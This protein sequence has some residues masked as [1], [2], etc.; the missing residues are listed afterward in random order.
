MRPVFNAHTIQNSDLAFSTKM[1][2]Q[3]INRKFEDLKVFSTLFLDY[4]N[5]DPKLASFVS[6][7]PNMESIKNQIELKKNSFGL[8]QRQI[9]V[10]RLS[11]Q[12]GKIGLSP[13]QSENLELLKKENTF[14]VSCGHQLNIAGGPVY[15]AY[16]I[17]S[18]IKLAE[19]LSKKFTDYQF[20]PIHWM[21]TEDHDLEEIS[22]FSFFSNKIEVSIPQQGAVGKMQTEGISDQLKKIKDFPEWMEA[23]YTKGENLTEATRL[24]IQSVF[25]SMGLLTIDGDDMELKGSLSDSQLEELLNP[26]VETKVAEN[27]DSLLKLGYKPQINPRKINLFYLEKDRRIRLEESDGKIQTIDEQFVWEKS[28]AIKFFKESPEKLSPNVALRPLYSQVLLPDVAFVGGPAEISY[29]LQLKKVFEYKNVPFPILFPRYSGLYIPLAQSKKMEKI[30]LQTSDIFLDIKDIKKNILPMEWERPLLE[31]VYSD[32][33]HFAQKIDATLEPLVRGELARMEKSVDGLEKR[34][35]KATEQKNEVLINQIN[36]LIGKLF[37]NGNLQERTE[38][39]ISFLATNK[40]WINEV[41]E[42]IDP[43][44]FSFS[45]IK[46]M[47]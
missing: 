9:L 38:S 1:A 4:I 17:L 27:S 8:N 28:E 42:V 20:V 45:V 5:A 18:V 43:F 40:N 32:L 41:Y 29:W 23:V 15:V 39:W 21:A 44:N 16:K 24:W 6:G 35:I 13:K 14:S 10:K 19:S 12:Y 30:G 46:E 22:S 7:F 26:W 36:G 33:I 37:P 31:R 11:A 2:T 34:I 25:G 47:D 3:T